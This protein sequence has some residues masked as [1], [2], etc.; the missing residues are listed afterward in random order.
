[1][2]VPAPA[3]PENDQDVCV[4]NALFG[5]RTARTLICL[6]FVAVRPQEQAGVHS[7]LTGEEAT[8]S[9]SPILMR[10]AQVSRSG[11]TGT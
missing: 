7:W 4:G 8:L 11:I 1:M 2:F 9:T 5:Y 10:V 6:F 3:A